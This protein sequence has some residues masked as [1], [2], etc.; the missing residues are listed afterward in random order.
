MI[1]WAQQVTEAPYLGLQQVVQTWQSGQFEQVGTY[2]LSKLNQMLSLPVENA[3]YLMR[4]TALLWVLPGMLL[5]SHSLWAVQ[6][7]CSAWSL[8][9]AFLAGL[10]AVRLLGAQGYTAR[11]ERLSILLATLFVVAFNPLFLRYSTFPS[12]SLF[13]L[14]FLLTALSLV[15]DR[16][17]SHQWYTPQRWGVGLQCVLALYAA[18]LWPALFLLVWGV[19]DLA[20]H[21]KQARTWRFWG[22]LTLLYVPA[23]WVL[24]HQHTPI[25]SA[26]GLS[27]I[28]LTSTSLLSAVVAS[29]SLG[30]L[31][32]GA[33]LLKSRQTEASLASH[34]SLLK[35]PWFW[36]CALLLLV[37]VVA[38]QSLLYLSLALSIPLGVVSLWP[39]APGR[40]YV[41]TLALVGAF[42]VSI[43]PLWI[44]HHSYPQEAQADQ[45]AQARMEITQWL[46]GRPLH[47]TTLF[48]S[49]PVS[50]RLFL[51]CLSVGSVL[52][53]AAD[54]TQALKTHETARFKASHYP[55]TPILSQ[56]WLVVSEDEQA[57]LQDLKQ[58]FGLK[59][60][61]KA[62]P[63]QVLELGARS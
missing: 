49:H 18:P 50:A 6:F 51:P 55:R 61:K 48:F 14:G 28:H 12:G 53:H 43:F 42:V 23:L 63:W 57:Y 21:A 44:V 41:G 11:H 26:L 60:L 40:K 37:A 62:G 24:G 15:G 4:S 35:T 19:W 5:G 45:Q 25:L 13:A 20:T 30:F 54:W 17:A 56:K 3:L 36:A 31:A 1:A 38:N 39:H 33:P 16:W 10:W 58:F 2:P 34:Q 8:W 7:F 29:S 59:V 32:L 22:S 46:Q 47:N 52:P 9:I 27:H